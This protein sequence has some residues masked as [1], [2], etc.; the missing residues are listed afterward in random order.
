[1]FLKIIIFFLYKKNIL[2]KLKRNS[3][4]IT[5]LYFHKFVSILIDKF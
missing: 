2:T 3:M 5:M 4:I 1:M